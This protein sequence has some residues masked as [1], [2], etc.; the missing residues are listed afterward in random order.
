MQAQQQLRISHFS[1]LW[2][3]VLFA[4]AAA[5]VLGGAVGYSLRPPS[6]GASQSTVSAQ[7]APA[8]PGLGHAVH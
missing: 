2:A 8:N 6:A 3:I 5:L 4:L 1:R 7:Q